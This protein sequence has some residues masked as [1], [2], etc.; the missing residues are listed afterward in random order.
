MR[1]GLFLVAQIVR[2]EGLAAVLAADVLVGLNA[3]SAEHDGLA[4]AGVE[5]HKTSKLAKLMLK[6]LREEAK[7]LKQELIDHG[8]RRL[9]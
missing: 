9:N 8:C 3:R 4:A 2:E 6:E 7:Q 5:S 1:R